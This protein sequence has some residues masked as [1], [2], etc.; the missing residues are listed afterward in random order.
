MW[1]VFSD[2]EETTL[3]MR[4]WESTAYSDDFPEW[5]VRFTAARTRRGPEIVRLTIEPRRPTA[6][7][8]GLETRLLRSIALSEFQR[9]VHEKAVVRHLDAVALETERPKETEQWLRSRRP[10][11]RGRED[12][13]YAVWAARYVAALAAP[14]PVKALSEAHHLSA[15]QIRNILYA[16]RDRGLLTDSPPGKAGGE[17]TPKARQLLREGGDDAS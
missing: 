5:Q 3:D 15:S 10:G 12:Y 13:Y 8:G 6:P 1:V 4:E 7:E 9:L 11:R 14:T 2:V 17:L 16:C